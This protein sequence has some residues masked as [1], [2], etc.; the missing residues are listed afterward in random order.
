MAGLDG[1]VAPWDQP[2][3]IKKLKSRVEE[4]ACKKAVCFFIK[5]SL[6]VIFHYYTLDSNDFNGLK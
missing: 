2:I 3:E 5:F 4:K 6:S 1:I